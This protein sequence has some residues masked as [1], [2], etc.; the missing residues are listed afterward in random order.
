MTEIGENKCDE[1]FKREVEILVKLMHPN[2]LRIYGICIDS[3]ND[4]TS[5]VVDYYAYSLE[6]FF[7][8]RKSKS[9]SRRKSKRQNRVNQDGIQSGA[10]EFWTPELVRMVAL[11]IASGEAQK[12][13]RPLTRPLTRVLATAGM[14][15]IH[16]KGMIHRDIKPANCLMTQD[17]RQVVV[18]D[19]GLSKIE[20]DKVEMSPFPLFLRTVP[21]LPSAA[22]NAT[23]LIFLFVRLLRLR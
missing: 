20:K 11:K 22:P 2:I 12:F 23:F 4:R 3:F 14:A 19:F 8:A 21:T 1:V 18:A 7:P 15:F 9:Q 13:N 5:L 17:M 10:I 16:S 6:V